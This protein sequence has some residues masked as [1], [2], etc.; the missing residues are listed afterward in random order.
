MVPYYRGTIDCATNLSFRHLLVPVVGWMILMT[1]GLLRKGAIAEEQIMEVRGSNS[2]GCASDLHRRV[3]F[4]AG[5]SFPP[6][7]IGLHRGVGCS[8]GSASLL[9]TEEQAQSQTSEVRG[10][11]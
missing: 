2:A 5:S 3:V 6:N 7:P 11:V 4:Q 8:W 9:G 10:P 1:S